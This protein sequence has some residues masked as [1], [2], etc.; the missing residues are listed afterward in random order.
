MMFNIVIACLCVCPCLGVSLCLSL[1]VCLSGSLIICTPSL[2]VSL[3]LSLSPWLSIMLQQEYVNVIQLMNECMNR[4]FSSH[5]YAF[6]CLSYATQP[7][8]S[9]TFTWV[10]ASTRGFKESSSPCSLPHPSISLK[11]F[12]LYAPVL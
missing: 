7:S 8:Q 6:V 4:S 3:S 10:V 11:L 5:V 2:S 12:F 9:V 1:S